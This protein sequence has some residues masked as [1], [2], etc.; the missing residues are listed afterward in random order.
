MV[1]EGCEISEEAFTDAV[2][3]LGVEDGAGAR[4]E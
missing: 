3:G 1:E 2:R 4:V